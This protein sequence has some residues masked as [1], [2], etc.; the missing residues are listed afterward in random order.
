[1]MQ[2]CP[3]CGFKLSE[4]T[5]DGELRKECPICQCPLPPAVPP[6]V[7]LPPA[8]PPDPSPAIHPT[9]LAIAK[10]VRERAIPAVVLFGLLTLILPVVGYF[11]EAQN[12]AILSWQSATCVITSCEVVRDYTPRSIRTGNLPIPK[13]SVRLSY[14]YTVNDYT[15][16]GHRGQSVSAQSADEQA[17][18][19]AV[20]TEHVVYFNPSIPNES[21]LVREG[22]EG[23]GLVVGI[24]MPTVFSLLAIGLYGAYVYAGRVV[25]RA[26]REPS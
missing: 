15:Y 21:L 14:S 19:Y 9:D 7:T 12:R 20:G 26:N 22:L 24:V 3:K 11:L 4:R 5:A 1:M 6:I 10:R 13:Y 2:P 23:G 18:K 25:A 16:E 17:A 8:G